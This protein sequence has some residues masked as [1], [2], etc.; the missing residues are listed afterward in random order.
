MCFSD[1][2]TSVKVRITDVGPR[3]SS[4]PSCNRC[5]SVSANN[6]HLQYLDQVSCLI[7]RSRFSSPS[8]M[9]GASSS[10]AQNGKGKQ[11]WPMGKSREFTQWTRKLSLEDK[12][13]LLNDALFMVWSDEAERSRALEVQCDI[14][15]KEYQRVL[16]AVMK[17]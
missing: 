14:L 4:M 8:A 11:S 12:S 7:S 16:P 2:L 3:P 13:R 9:S 10:P 1:Y 15:V 17:T 6:M 5:P